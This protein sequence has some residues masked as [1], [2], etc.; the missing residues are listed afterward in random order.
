MRLKG[1]L[2]LYLVRRYGNISGWNSDIAALML[3]LTKNIAFLGLKILPEKMGV[4]HQLLLLFFKIYKS[5]YLI[6]L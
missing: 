5:N 6:Y 1:F 4:L 3:V 2:Y